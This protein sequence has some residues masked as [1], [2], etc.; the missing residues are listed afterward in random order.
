METLAKEDVMVTYTTLYIHLLDQYLWEL[1][2]EDETREAGEM[3]L[4]QLRSKYGVKADK[5]GFQGQLVTVETMMEAWEELFLAC[6]EQCDECA[7]V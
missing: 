1:L 7:S 6:L 4:R 3:L 2:S 5:K